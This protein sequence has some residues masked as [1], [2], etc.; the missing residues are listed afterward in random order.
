MLN[1]Q[2]IVLNGIGRGGT[3]IV[4]N[5]LQSHPNI[6][7]PIGETG[8]TIYPNWIKKN[9]LV[10]TNKKIFRILLKS[11]L[12]CLAR[13]VDNI[14]YENKMRTLNHPDNKY[15]KYNEIYSCEEVENAI[16]CTKSINSDVELTHFFVRNFPSVACIG[17]ARSSLAVC[18]GLMRRGSQVENAAKKYNKVMNEI[19]NQ[20]KEIDKYLIVRF[21][22]CLDN[23]FGEIENMYKFLGVSPYKLKRIRLKSKKIIKESGEHLSAFGAEHRKVWVEKS[24]IEDYLDTSVTKRQIAN[25]SNKDREKILNITGPIMDQFGYSTK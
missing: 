13:Y 12:K 4:W 23:P 2:I 19:V 7:T 25:L 22:D 9:K 16:L 17:V 20:K 3:N 6:V 8:N 1:K 5:L 24:F 11:N 15:K 10:K 21:E 14:L 18:E